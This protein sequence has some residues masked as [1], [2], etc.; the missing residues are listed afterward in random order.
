MGIHPS[1][2]KHPMILYSLDDLN[3]FVDLKAKLARQKSE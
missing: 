2:H 1:T 3:N